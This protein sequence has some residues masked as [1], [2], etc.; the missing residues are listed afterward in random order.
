MCAFPRKYFF[1]NE[2]TLKA[3]LPLNGYN[4]FFDEMEKMMKSKGINI[5]FNKAVTLRYVENIKKIKPFIK[6][7]Q[8]DTDY[9]IWCCNPVKL[10]YEAGLG[11]LDSPVSKFRHLHCFIKNL[12]I[13]SLLIDVQEEGYIKGFDHKILETFNYCQLLLKGGV[14]S[15]MNKLDNK[16]VLGLAIE[17]R[18]LWEEQKSIHL[19]NHNRIFKKRK[20]SNYSG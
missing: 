10:V 13:E 18:L 14:L 11:K 19:R 12:K 2:P 17:N 4:V 7:K 5:N 1:K 15:I 20:K 16:N 6:T 3:A 9:V 8:I